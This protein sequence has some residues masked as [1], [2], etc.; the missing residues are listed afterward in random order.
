[1]KLWC[2]LLSVTALITV[3][4][5]ACD[6]DDA[7]GSDSTGAGG[8]SEGGASEGGTSSVGGSAMGGDGAGGQTVV[9]LTEQTV[10]TC[11]TRDDGGG[12]QQ[13]MLIEGTQQNWQTTSVGDIDELFGNGACHLVID[14]AGN[15]KV[16]NAN[17]EFQ[18]EIFSTLGDGSWHH[19]GVD[20]YT[21]VESQPQGYRPDGVVDSLG[22]LSIATVQ[23]DDLSPLSQGGENGLLRVVQP[24][25]GEGQT[26]ES[27]TDDYQPYA[28]TTLAVDTKDKTY[29]VARFENQTEEQYY[30]QYASAPPGGSWSNLQTIPLPPVASAYAAFDPYAITDDLDRLHVFYRMDSGVTCDLRRIIFDA[31]N[32]TWGSDE[33]IAEFGPTGQCGVSEFQVAR[34]PLGRFYVG[35]RKQISGTDYLYLVSDDGST[36]HEELVTSASNSINAV[37]TVSD[38]VFVTLVYVDTTGAVPQLQAAVKDLSTTTWT[39]TFI[40]DDFTGELAEGATQIAGVRNRSN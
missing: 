31:A 1:M 10:Y 21:N 37:N 7:P 27:L 33:K 12:E 40:T 13:F 32:S 23:F 16:F 8:S 25:G 6:D 20:A 34:D 9:P 5:V 28:R 26:I 35:Y 22:R 29:W 30:L 17:Q 14:R 2:W 24:L 39:T 3:G 38:G 19:H 15:L 4:L 11:I 18:I 36:W